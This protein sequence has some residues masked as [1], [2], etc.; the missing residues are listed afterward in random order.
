[1]AGWRSQQLLGDRIDMP[2]TPKPVIDRHAIGHPCEDRLALGV[3]RADLM[4]QL[5]ALRRKRDR[6]REEVERA[7]RVI[8]DETVATAIRTT[9]CE[10]EERA[11]GLE[12]SP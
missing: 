7:E 6:R 3:R 10:A 9:R 2:Q 12:R 8:F 1:C 5:G 11:K 4:R